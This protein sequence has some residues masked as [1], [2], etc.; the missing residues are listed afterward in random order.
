MD[1]NLLISFTHTTQ[2]CSLIFNNI[3][4]E[5]NT[6]SYENAI[7]F[8]NIDAIYL[9]LKL[10]I[11]YQR[12]KSYK[13]PKNLIKITTDTKCKDNSIY[14]YHMSF[15]DLFDHNT[16]IEHKILRKY[17]NNHNLKIQQKNIIQ[18]DTSAQNTL[19]TLKLF[20]ESTNLTK[21]ERRL[22]GI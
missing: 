3:T 13:L 10:S 18:N 11:K 19:E 12:K 15:S 9:T 17:Y 2:K 14:I 21:R 6:F 20:G 5:N 8:T 4:Y 7:L 22:L 16:T 1:K